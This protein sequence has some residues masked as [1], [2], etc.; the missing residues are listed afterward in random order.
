MPKWKHEE[1]ESMKRTPHE[2]IINLPG[3]FARVT[4]PIF[5]YGE[6]L[7]RISF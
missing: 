7:N 3:K 1:F 6:V 2:A 4:S 5:L